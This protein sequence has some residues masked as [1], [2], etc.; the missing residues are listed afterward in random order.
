M[1]FWWDLL[2]LAKK[3]G[4]YDTIGGL[5]YIVPE[6]SL[7]NG[8]RKVYEDGQVLEMVELALKSRCVEVC[9]NHGVELSHIA[10]KAKKL[11]PKRAPPPT[12][13]DSLRSSPRKCGSSAKKKPTDVA[14]ASQPKSTQKAK[15]LPSTQK[16]AFPKDTCLT[17]PTKTTPKNISPIKNNNIQQPQPSQPLHSPSTPDPKPSL[18]YTSLSFSQTQTS[19]IQGEVEN[20]FLRDYEWEDPRDDSPV[21]LHEYEFNDSEEDQDPLYNPYTDKGKS[22][23]QNSDDVQYIDG[24]DECTDDDDYTYGDGGIGIDLD[25]VNLEYECESEDKEVDYARFQSERSAEQDYE[26]GE[27]QNGGDGYHSEYED[28]EDDIHTPPDSGDVGERKKK[29]GILVGAN[30]DFS[31]FKW[32]VGQRFPNRKA[33]KD[34]VAMYGVL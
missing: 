14:A 3:C 29:K 16:D 23:V 9:V 33:F 6:Q 31:K 18:K 17:G 8:L 15:K 4:D 32:T 12:L 27:P 11:Q 25:N 34:A 21:N 5:L 24:D 1:L 22:V 30:T 10:P 26:P 28:S 2:E 19:P 13:L 7:A 20:E